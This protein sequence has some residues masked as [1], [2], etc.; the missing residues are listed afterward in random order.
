[1]TSPWRKDSLPWKMVETDVCL[2]PPAKL[3]IDFCDI[4]PAQKVWV[5]CGSEVPG[6]IGCNVANEIAIVHLRRGFWTV[7][8]PAFLLSCRESRG[9]EIEFYQCRP[10]KQFEIHNNEWIILTSVGNEKNRGP[11][12]TRFITQAARLCK[13]LRRQNFEKGGHE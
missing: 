11:K 6:S 5:P 10:P 8:I 3:L 13:E 2:S 4:N 12:R 9:D 7:W 1:M